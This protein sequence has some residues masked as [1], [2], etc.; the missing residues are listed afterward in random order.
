MVYINDLPKTIQG[1]VSMYADDTSLCHM[2]NDISKL[3][4]AINED[5]ELLD[6]WL[7]GNKLSLNV[8]KTKSMLICTKSRGKTLSTNDDKL[9]FLTRDRGLKSVD[10]IKY[11]GVHVDY[12]LSWKDHLQC[13][14]SKVSRG[15]GML[16]QAKYFLPE[17]FLKTLYSS[18]VVEPYFRYCCSVWGTCG[19]TVKPTFKNFKTERLE[20]SPT[21]NLML[22][23]DHLRKTWMENHR[24]TDCRRIKDNC[25]QVSL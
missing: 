14:T 9:T 21:A 17:V 1:K 18:I 8:A 20:L 4:S 22:S 5:L 23:A 24:R 12:S 16:K 15:M 11:H 3:E 2:C 7:K 6:N 10:V 25:L 19:V 13:V